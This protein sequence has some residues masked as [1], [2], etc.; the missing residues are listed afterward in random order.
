M[1]GKMEPGQPQEALCPPVWLGEQ[2]HV[3]PCG[4]DVTYNVSG[5]EE[6]LWMG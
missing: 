6:A 3:F 4:I 5:P 2:H 1:S